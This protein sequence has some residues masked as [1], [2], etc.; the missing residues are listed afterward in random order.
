[1]HELHHQDRAGRANFDPMAPEVVANPYPFYAEL[2]RRGPVV[3]S[4]TLGRW[5][6]AGYD[7]VVDV[8][9]DVAT[10]SSAGGVSM[11][12][13]GAGE[14]PIDLPGQVI[15]NRAGLA[16][17]IRIRAESC[18]LGTKP[19]PSSPDGVISLL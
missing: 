18:I 7:A 2:R 14:P 17:E 1:V 16:A 3:W 13:M 4:E 5:L 10:F 19:T 11:R 8:Y 15:D 12:P 6:I 9:R